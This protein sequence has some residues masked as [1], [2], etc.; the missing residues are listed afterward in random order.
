MRAVLLP[1]PSLTDPLEP[2]DRMPVSEADYW[3]FY[4]LGLWSGVS[5]DCN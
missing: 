5:L 1:R 4:Y 3:K 2:C